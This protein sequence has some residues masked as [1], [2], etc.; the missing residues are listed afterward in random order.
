MMVRRK[1][2]CSTEVPADV[3]PRYEAITAL[4]D[5]FCKRYLNEEYAEMCRRLTAKL[6]RKWPTPVKRG[7]AEVWACGIVRT[8]GWANMLDDPKTSP[9]MKLIHIDPEFGVANSTGQGKSMAIK[10]MF[11]IGRLN[12]DWTLPSRLSDNPL[13]QMVKSNR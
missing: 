6:T 2:L 11:G 4:T 1:T 3:R 13:V 9:Y 5:A 12:V 7:R 10:R 8:I